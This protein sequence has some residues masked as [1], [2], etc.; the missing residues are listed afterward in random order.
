MQAYE[1]LADRNKDLRKT[2]L[3]LLEEKRE[4]LLQLQQGNRAQSE[5]SRLSEVCEELTMKVQ[6]LES[7][8]KPSPVYQVKGKFR[9]FI[10][11]K[12]LTCFA[13]ISQEPD[14]RRC[15]WLR[16]VVFR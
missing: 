14:N 4:L 11:Y 9:I 13:R 1:Q 3:K 15:L 12:F 6:V 5:V 7:S 8:Q 10:N 16:V 2:N